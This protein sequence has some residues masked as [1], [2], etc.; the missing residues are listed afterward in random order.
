MS[1][2][3][4][5][6]AYYEGTAMPARLARRYFRMMGDAGRILD[7]GCGC[8]DL[9]RHRPDRGIELHG[10]DCDTMA[11]R[12][13]ERFEIVR[14]V[15]LESE[16]LPYP[17]ASFDAVLAKDVLEHLHDPSALV[18]EI[19]RVLKPGGLLI[20]SVVMARPRRVWADYTHIRGFTERAARL[21]VED[22]GFS[23]ERTWPMGGVPLSSRLG[24]IDLVP[25]LLRL[26]LF[27]LLWGSSW[28]L[29]ASK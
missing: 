1:E 11:L 27:N 4:D 18:A 9:G 16:S 2:R 26:P 28:E 17:D 5:K 29:C 25:S 13:A 12:Q 24:F 20:A 8:G 10:V 22:A 21:L 15:D 7:V 23:V 3:P 19:H 14:R 6:L